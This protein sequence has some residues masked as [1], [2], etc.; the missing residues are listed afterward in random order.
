MNYFPN[1]KY[2]PAL[3]IPQRV[4]KET[5]ESIDGFLCLNVYLLFYPKEKL[6]NYMSLTYLM[7]PLFLKLKKKKSTIFSP[8]SSSKKETGFRNRRQLGYFL[9][10]YMLNL[11]LSKIGL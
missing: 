6:Q 11:C 2:I 1:Q 8:Y 3:N 4:V 9:D 5:D 10:P 7:K